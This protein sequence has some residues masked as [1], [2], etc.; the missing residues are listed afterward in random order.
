MQDPLMITVRNFCET[1]S[2]GKTTA[3]R[4]IR[5]GKVES[6]R[7]GR[8]RL[9]VMESVRALLNLPTAPGGHE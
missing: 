4:L 8:R 2:C 7:I 1:C 6:R 9:I 3:Y 5:E